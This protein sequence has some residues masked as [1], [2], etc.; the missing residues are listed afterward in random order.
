MSRTKVIEILEITGGVLLLT[1]GFYFF[2]LPQN[3]VIGGVMGISVLVQDFLP[4]S[5]FILVANIGLLALGL[6]FLGK[7][8]FLKNCLCNSFISRDSFYIRKNC[9]S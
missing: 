3:L 6:I 8:F 5:T 1:L 9:C 7:T 2:L 4:V